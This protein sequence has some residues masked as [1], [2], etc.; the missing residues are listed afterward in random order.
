VG[1]YNVGDLLSDLHGGMERRR[2]LLKNQAD[3]SA[4]NF[5]EVLR[6]V[7]EQIFSFEQDRTLLDFSVG[8]QKAH[9]SG[10]KG[11]LAGAGFAED[12]KDFSGGEVKI[13][14][15]EGR[16]EFARAGGVRDVEIP[17][18]KKRRHF[19]D[20]GW[21]LPAHYLWSIKEES[22]TRRT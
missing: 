9:E 18:F 12:A 22:G 4:A 6:K 10:G 21:A 2:R 17:D 15:C 19:L 1:G 7:A 16:A 3:A 14:A 13:H 5:P 8:W 11:A 20:Q